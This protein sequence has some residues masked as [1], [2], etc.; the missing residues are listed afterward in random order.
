MHSSCLVVND[1]A[2]TSCDRQTAHSIVIDKV[3]DGV[4]V[5]W[6][7]LTSAYRGQW[8]GTTRQLG[9]YHTQGYTELVKAHGC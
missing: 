4:D 3:V 2:L 1:W 7:R 9:G 5:V 6:E 8:D